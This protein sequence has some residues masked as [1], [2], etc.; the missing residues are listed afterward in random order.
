MTLNIQRA[1]GFACLAASIVILIPALDRVG[2]PTW[3]AAAWGLLNF[4]GIGF[5]TLPQAK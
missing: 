1:I 4:V 3:A 5:L 2:V